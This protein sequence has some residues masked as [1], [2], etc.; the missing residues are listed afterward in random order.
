MITFLVPTFNEKEN[1]FILVNTINN[2]ELSFDYD[3][4]FIDDNSNDG[5]IKESAQLYVGKDRFVVRKEIAIELKKQDFLI[6]SQII[7]YKHFWATKNN[8]PLK[9][10]GCGFI[11]LKRGAKP[12]N[13][14]ELV[15]V[16]VGPKSIERSTKIM[17]NM[18]NMFRISNN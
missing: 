15:P 1:I 2:L 6:Q 13:V 7:L 18:I 5:T 12:G 17:R 8:I 16:S 4:L 10:V 3:F 14:C 11:L 9:D